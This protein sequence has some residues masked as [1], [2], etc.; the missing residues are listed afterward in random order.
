[1][2]IHTF[3][4]RLRPG[5]PVDAKSTV[6]SNNLPPR[7]ASFILERLKPEWKRW[8]YALLPGTSANIQVYVKVLADWMAACDGRIWLPTPLSRAA[9]LLP[10]KKSGYTSTVT[11]T[12]G[13]RSAFIEVGGDTK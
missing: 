12:S 7:A 5:T 13:E 9:M 1:M 3:H 4:A 10:G 2:R 8:S 11:V 6:M